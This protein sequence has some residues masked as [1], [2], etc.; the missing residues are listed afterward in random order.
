MNVGAWRAMTLIVQRDLRLSFRRPEQVLQPLVFFLIVTTLFPLG[1]SVQLSFLRD[2]APGVFA[3]LPHCFL[4]FCRWIR[5]SR[6]MRTM[7][8]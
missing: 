2:M 3:G 8:L 1:L 4:R 7:E 5:C 6:T